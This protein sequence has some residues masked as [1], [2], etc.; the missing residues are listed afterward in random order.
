M[1]AV[2]SGHPS[3]A[4]PPQKRWGQGLMLLLFVCLQCWRCCS[5][6]TVGAGRTVRFSPSWIPTMTSGRTSSIT[7]RREWVSGGSLFFVDCHFDRDKWL[8]KCEEC[9]AEF[10]CKRRRTHIKVMA[11]WGISAIVLSL[12]YAQPCHTHTYFQAEPGCKL[13]LPY[14]I[15]YVS[16]SSYATPPPPPTQDATRPG[17]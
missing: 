11:V 4:P 15:M 16:L 6:C 5:S 13:G 8:I 9:P 3:P 14:G 17:P 1:C 12:S 10:N 7:T 2:T